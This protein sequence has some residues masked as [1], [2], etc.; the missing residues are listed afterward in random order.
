MED[1][2]RFCTCSFAGFKIMSNIQ[3]SLNQTNKQTTSLD[4][5]GL[6]ANYFIS[7]LFVS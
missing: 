1:T 2:R 7:F 3:L 4:R 6:Q 5:L